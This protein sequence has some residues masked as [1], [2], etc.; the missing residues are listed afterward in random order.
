MFATSADD[1][2]GGTFHLAGG[3]REDAS[4]R[5]HFRSFQIVA[6]TTLG[7]KSVTVALAAEHRPETHRRHGRR[8]SVGGKRKEMADVNGISSFSSP[9]F[10][11]GIGN[12]ESSKKDGSTADT[13]EH[14]QGQAAQ[15][16]DSRTLTS[17]V[18]SADLAKYP[19]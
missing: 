15:F 9:F 2:L 3:F 14:P 5:S 18:G 16:Q 4:D 1:G 13:D 8:M 17:K 10:F 12:K 19:S 7:Q 11:L 6:A